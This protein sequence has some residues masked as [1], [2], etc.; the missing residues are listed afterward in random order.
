MAQ[1]AKGTRVTGAE[2]E[3]LIA[4]L[5]R[6]YQEGSSVRALARQTGRSY[7]FVHSVL[8]EAGVTLRGR[9]GAHRALTK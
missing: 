9:G 5:C 8:T 2:R 3:Q 4:T 6:S 7:G 1:A